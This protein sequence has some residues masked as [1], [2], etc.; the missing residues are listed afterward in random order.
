MYAPFFM[1]RRRMISSGSAG[2]I[3]RRRAPHIEYRG[4]GI[5]RTAQSFVTESQSSALYIEAVK[6]L[7][8]RFFN[9]PSRN[10]SSRARDVFARFS[11]K[12]KQKSSK[13]RNSR[14]ESAASRPPILPGC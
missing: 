11:A 14:A 13:K 4:S 9:E 3:A 2:H 5:Y 12:I 6:K 10:C 7:A 8:S 1:R